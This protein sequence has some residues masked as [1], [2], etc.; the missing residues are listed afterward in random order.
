M[1]GRARPSRSATDAR[2]AF[3]L[4]RVRAIPR[5]FV[6]TYGDIDRA[7]PRWVGLV[8]ART[9]EDVPW[10]RVVRA[11]GVAPMGA[12]QLRRLRGEGVA[13]RGRRVDLRRARY[14]DARPDPPAPR[15]AGGS[16]GRTRRRARKPSRRP[17]A[18]DGGGAR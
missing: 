4:Q 13:L 15:A 10:H 18:P 3:I 2:T 17:E 11:D 14:D 5:G 8:L 1:P 7:A 12:A 16:R 9:S 6:R